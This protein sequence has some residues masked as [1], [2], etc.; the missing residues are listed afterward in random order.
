MADIDYY[1]LGADRPG[2]ELELAE[3]KKK[4]KKLE[5]EIRE[6]KEQLEY[7]EEEKAWTPPP[8]CTNVAGFY[9]DFS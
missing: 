7:Y 8:G 5:H 4:I 6:L 9:G 2:L 1:K 3:A